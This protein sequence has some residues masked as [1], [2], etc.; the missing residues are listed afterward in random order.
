MYKIYM[1]KYLNDDRAF[2]MYNMQ[3]FAV[4]LTYFQQF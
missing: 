1:Q 4:L 3:H 2:G